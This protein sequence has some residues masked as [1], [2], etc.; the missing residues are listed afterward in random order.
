VISSLL[1]SG[2]VMSGGIVTTLNNNTQQWDF[3]NAWAPLQWMIVRG[4]NSS[5]YRSDS[6]IDNFTIYN[7]TA[8]PKGQAPPAHA[9]DIIHPEHWYNCTSSDDLSSCSWCFPSATSLS[10][11]LALRWMWSNFLAFNETGYMLE[12]YYAPTPG[13]VGAGGEYKLQKGFGW[14]N[15]VAL[16]FMTRLSDIAPEKLTIEYLQQQPFPYA[17]MAPKVDTSPLVPEHPPN[18]IS[19]H[20]IEKSHYK[21]QDERSH[22]G[23]RKRSKKAGDAISRPDLKGVGVKL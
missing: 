5:V 2:L 3:P 7:S 19:A 9:C 15:G 6:T 1:Q 22:P 20:P 23:D 10:T 13:G 21:Y 17:E 12:K 14:T 18:V 11:A 16:D 8:L 4:I